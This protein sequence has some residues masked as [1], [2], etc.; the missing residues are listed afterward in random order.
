LKTRLFYSERFLI[1]FVISTAVPEHIGGMVT[2]ILFDLN[3]T[4]LSI[5]LDLVAI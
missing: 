1:D 2:K 3:D 4:A 5:N